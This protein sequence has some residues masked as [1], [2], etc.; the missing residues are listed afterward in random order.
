M[1]RLLTP[2]LFGLLLIPLVLPGAASAQARTFVASGNGEAADTTFQSVD[3]SGCIQTFVSLIGVDERLKE[4]GAPSE[5]RSWAG[6]IISQFDAC[7]GSQ[8]VAAIGTAD[9]GPDA[10][11]MDKLDAATLN[12]TIMV[13]D[14]VSGTSYP[15]EIAVTWQATADPVRIAEQRLIWERGLALNVRID[16]TSRAGTAS[17][18]VTDGATNYTPEQGTALLSTGRSIEVSISH[19]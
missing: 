10:F 1:R 5:L 19:E 16:G 8:L 11:Q 7:A 2:V 17:G 12:A 15:V 13:E 9:L 4:S 18:T 3:A 6:V 14:F